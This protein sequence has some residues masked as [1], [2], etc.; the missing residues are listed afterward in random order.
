MQGKEARKN[1][2]SR[3]P[4]LL[5]ANYCAPI[6]SMPPRVR[7]K[8]ISEGGWPIP[9]A[10]AVGP[11]ASYM[12]TKQWNASPLVPGIGLEA[13]GWKRARLYRVDM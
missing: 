2:Q 8:P 3:I 1:D 13:M 4:L 12:D 9:G 10:V 11:P 5:G 6:C 7:S